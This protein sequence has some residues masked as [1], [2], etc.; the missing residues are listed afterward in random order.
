M[1]D[2]EQIRLIVTY[3]QAKETLLGWLG[4]AAFIMILWLSN[5]LQ[6]TCNETAYCHKLSM[7]SKNTC[8]SISYSV[9]YVS[10]PW[11]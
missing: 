5:R 4:T 8:I 10:F 3:R 7:K 1:T 2:P 9:C 11:L 6:I